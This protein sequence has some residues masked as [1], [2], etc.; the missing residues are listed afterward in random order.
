MI[1]KIETTDYAR[2][3]EIWENSV[4]FTHDFLKEE[5]FN[6][7]KKQLPIYFEQVSLVGFENEGILVGFIGIAKDNLEMLFIHNDYRG[8]GIGKRLLNH[9]IN[10]YQITKVDV[11]EQNLQALEFYKHLG[12]HVINRSEVDGAGKDYP[13]LHMVL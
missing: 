13:I 5:G 4:Y 12:F 8:K 7:Y 2:L 6:Y 1:R 9:A 10:H 3:Q 11:N